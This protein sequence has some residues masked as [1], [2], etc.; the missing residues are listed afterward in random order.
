MKE[1][2]DTKQF[3]LFQLNYFENYYKHTYNA[4]L[5]NRGL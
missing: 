4:N 5:G 2:N 1:S 3:S